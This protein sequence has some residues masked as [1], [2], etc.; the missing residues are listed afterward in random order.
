M[1]VY[2]QF[3]TWKKWIADATHWYGQLRYED[4]RIVELY[5]PVNSGMLNFDSLEELREVAISVF[6]ETATED[7]VL[8]EGFPPYLDQPAMAVGS[9]HRPTPP[10]LSDLLGIAPDTLAGEPSETVVARIR[11]AWDDG[12]QCDLQDTPNAPADWHGKE[13]PCYRPTPPQ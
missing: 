8:F 1:K 12:C 5:H 4:G 3:S 2:A 13:C 6:C 11:S 10:M 7:D 9:N